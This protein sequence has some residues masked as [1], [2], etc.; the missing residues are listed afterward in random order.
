VAAA[1]AHALAGRLGLPPENLRTDPASGRLT[2]VARDGVGTLLAVAQALAAD[3]IAVAD[4]S[5]RGP[6]LDEAF[7]ALTGQHAH[8]EAS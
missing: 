2:L 3:G 6:S 5:L 1:A 8:R 4:L 7:L